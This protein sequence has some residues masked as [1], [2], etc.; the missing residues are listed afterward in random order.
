[1]DDELSEEEL[2]A[3]VLAQKEARDG[4]DEVLEK[5]RR[6]RRNAPSLDEIKKNLDEKI[7]ELILSARRK[8]K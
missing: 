6:G 8:P 3:K 5:S 1:M 2:R 4:F 7:V